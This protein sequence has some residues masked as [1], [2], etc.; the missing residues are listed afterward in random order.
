MDTPNEITWKPDA[1]CLALDGVRGLAI[2]SVTVYRLCKE[3]NPDSNQLFAWV[4]SLA[5]FG[6][7]G[8]DLFFV[9]SGF[10]ITGI[11]LRSRTKPNYFRNFIIRRSLRIFPLYFL[12][13]M[14]GLWVLPML[15]TSDAF[16]SAKDHQLYLWTY[17]SNLKMSWDNQWCFGPFDHFWSLCV[18]EH[19]YFLWP[20]VVLMLTRRPLA[21]LCIGLFVIIGCARTFAASGIGWDV[22]ASVATFF[23][24]D[25][26]AIGA[27]AAVLLSSSINRDQLRSTSLLIAVVL[28]PILVGIGLSGR[29]LYEIP[30]SLCPAFFA[31]GLMFV[32]LNPPKSLIVR[33][34]ELRWLRTLGQYSYGMY[35]VQLPLVSLLPLRLASGYLPAN[36]LLAG[37]SYLGLMFATILL[38]AMASYHLFEKHFLK[39]K[40]SFA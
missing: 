34:F 32:L 19:F 36:D 8:V 30:H 1:H 2:L 11:L 24:A 7:R 6:E 40:A 10:L 38:T 5:P 14:L 18:E 31:A 13:L 12:S 35:V 29:R 9:L 20:A 4:R 23:R 17:T 27:L 3:L 22:A 15:F 21:A 33:C 25:A 37:G 26:L 28:L 39:L 16:D